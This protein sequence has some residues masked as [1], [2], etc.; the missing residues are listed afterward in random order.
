VNAR[1]LS[2][3]GFLIAIVGLVGLFYLG[4][5]FARTPV[6]IGVQV[7]AVLLMIWAR[8]T[9]GLRSFHLEAHPTQGG[10]VTTGPYR[11]VRHPIYA[12]ILYFT[13]AA[14][15]T[16]PAAM[17]IACGLLIAGGLALRITC[18]EK[19]VREMYPDYDNYARQTRRVIPFVL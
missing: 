19:L 1:A 5:L 4:S 8:V 15:L 10:L 9:F 17:T 3:V 12:A 18:E 2:V 14:V 16:R 11:F 6:L 13:A 7:A